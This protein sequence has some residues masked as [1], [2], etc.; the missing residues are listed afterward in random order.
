M[1]LVSSL[2]LAQSGP[3][4]ATAPQQALELITTFNTDEKDALAQPPNADIAWAD[5]GVHTSVSTGIV[6]SVHSMPQSAAMQAFTGG[7]SRKYHTLDAVVKAIKSS[8]R[9]LSYTIPMIWDNIGNGWQLKSAAPDGSLMDFVGISGLGALYVMSGRVEKCA[10]AADLF[11][12]SLYATTGGLSITTPKKTTFPQG[13][14]TGGIALFSDGTGAAGSVGANHYANPTVDTSGRFKNVWFAFGSFDANFGA[15]L[16][17]MTIKPNGLFPNITSGARV[18][19]VFGGTNMRD[20][21]FRMMVSDL[22]MQTTTATGAKDQTSGVVAGA[23]IS[24]PYSYAKTM[25]ITEENFVGTAFGP[26]RFWILPHLDNHPYLV[27]NPTADFWINVSAQ[28]GAAS[29]AKLACSSKD[30]VPTFRMYGPG[31]ARAMGDRMMRWEGDLDGG[32]E[33]GDPG[34]ID[35]FGS[36]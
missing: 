29:W 10:F 26:R 19:D 27:Q 7:G 1:A 17:K 20:K 13:L 14:S 21:F 28:P 15:S 24:N 5:V 25:G 4:S 31:D 36:I 32:S 8:A 6:K 35:M 30:W 12:Q 34:R 22:V 2:P 9:E 16:V 23:A 11:Y 18:T 33:P 3:W